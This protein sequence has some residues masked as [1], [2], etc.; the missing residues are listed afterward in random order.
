VMTEFVHFYSIMLGFINYRLYHLT[1]LYYPPQ[2]PG[3]SPSELEKELC[4]ESQYVSE[5]IGSLNFSLSKSEGASGSGEEE[6]T[7]DSF[8]QEEESGD[9][10]EEQR[11]EM[12][13][14]TRLKTL[15]QGMKF[16]LGRECPR[17]PLTFII[18]CLGGEV[19]WDRMLFVGA[20]YDEDNE[21]ITHQIT[22]RP[23]LEKRFMSR[24]YV[25]PQWVFDCLNFRRLAKVEDY[26]PGIVLPPHISP[27][28]KERDGEY[29]PPERK[30]FLQL[31]KGMETAIAEGKEVDAASDEEEDSVSEPNEESESDDPDYNSG[32][33][34]NKMADVAEVSKKGKKTAKLV[35]EQVD[36]P[37]P[38]LSMKEKMLRDM[39]AE[40][41]QPERMHKWLIYSKDKKERTGLN[42]MMIKNKHKRL[43]RSLMYYRMERSKEAKLLSKKR[44]AL[45]E[46]EK[47]KRRELKK[48]R[49]LEQIQAF[50]ISTQA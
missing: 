44:K 6:T 9:K 27:F 32:P 3:C 10:L 1:N 15:F 35:E 46:E 29:M 41:G 47:L 19:S 11:I 49:Q 13:A 22:D 39:K 50:E 36:S 45:D 40:T 26:F 4:D 7:I 2:I 33:R 17:E 8:E 37:E 16:F 20:T 25:Q 28:V 23:N 31:L 48:Q 12:E 24:Y 42:K 30:E 34:K 14:V 43:Y 38:E 21:S 5:R 18:R